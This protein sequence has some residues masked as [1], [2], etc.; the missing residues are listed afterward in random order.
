MTS[1]TIARKMEDRILQWINVD[2]YL[3][4]QLDITNLCNLRCVHC[5]HPHHR[6]DGAISIEQWFSILDQYFIMI[7]RLKFRPLILLCGGEPVLSP[8][9]QPILDWIY[10]RAPQTRLV[11]LTNG[12]LAERMRPDEF[13]RFKGISIQ[14]SLDGPDAASHDRIR[15]VGN[16]NKSIAGTQFLLAR[17]LPVYFQ[18]VLSQR[19]SPMIP[20]FFDLAKKV[21]VSQMD[22]TRLI[23]EGHAK[24]LVGRGEDEVLAPEDLRRAYQMMLIESARS[25]VRTD[26]NQP[27]FTLLHPGLGRSGRFWEGIVVDYQGNILASSRSR[28]KLGNVLEVGL[29]RL[30]LHHPLF[31]SLRRGRI[32]SCG[33]CPNFSR[34]AGDRNAAYAETGDYLA[35]DPGC[36]LLSTSVKK[37]SVHERAVS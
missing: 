1:R 24:D 21:G 6:N 3:P 31:A 37:E 14:V 27:L 17:G 7:E 29:E 32:K 10:A 12:T 2:R 22:F 5:Y 30:Y 4:L 9:F 18:A 13:K 8:H 23:R 16:F 26:T 11:I 15:G 19:S 25:G 36:W 28:L 33:T 35:A 34:C 20:A